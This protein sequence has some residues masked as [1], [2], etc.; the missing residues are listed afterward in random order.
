MN[1][2]LLFG[3]AYLGILATRGFVIGIRRE[4]NQ[5]P[6]LAEWILGSMIGVLAAEMIYVLFR[7]CPV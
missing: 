5:K 3:A 1:L 2:V 7:S 6:V 4:A